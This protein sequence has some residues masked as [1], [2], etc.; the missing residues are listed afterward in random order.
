MVPIRR[1][2]AISFL[3][4]CVTTVAGPVDFHSDIMPLLAERCMTCHSE[5]GVSFSFEDADR[6]YDLRMAI[7]S[8]IAANRMPPWLAEP[9]HQDYV[10]DFSLDDDEKAMVA[11]WA[12]A[13]YP[14]GVP[15]R[16]AATTRA[17]GDFDTDLSLDVLPDG[18]YL[19]NQER[20]DDYRCFLIDWPYSTE[21]FVTGFRAEPGNFRVSHHLVNFAVG[22]EGAE[23]LKTLSAE[24]DGPGHQCFGGP[25]PDRMGNEEERARLEERYP[26]GWDTLAANYFW[27]SQWAPGTVGFEFPEASGVLIRPGSVIVV[28]MHY[29]SAFAPGERDVGTKMHFRVADDVEKPSVVMPMTDNRWLYGSRNKTLQIAP[30]A[31]TTYETSRSFEQIAGYTARALKIDPERVGAVELQSANVHMH[32]FGVAGSTSLLHSDGRKE[33]LLNIP[34]WDLDWQRDF[35]FTQGKL[36]PRTEFEKTSLIVE[37]T[38]SNYTDQTVYG[39][40]G[41]DDEMCFNFSYVSLVLD[42]EG[43]T[44][45]RGD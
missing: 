33:T 5:T 31:E 21:K 19:P 12:E 8:A 1:Y 18:S 11:E 27:L 10:G 42:E 9:G 39:G 29:Y 7:A 15:V 14:L 26:G 3:L 45:A 16:T 36:I 43:Q 38:F 2:L 32:A 22:P 37:C 20:K 41:S 28:Q 44:A 13:G 25:L 35:R 6:T 40:Y 23:L 17:A 24:E 34:R 4:P 30:G